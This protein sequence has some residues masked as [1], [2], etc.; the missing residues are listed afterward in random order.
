MCVTCACELAQAHKSVYILSSTQSFQLI[1]MWRHIRLNKKLLEKQTGMSLEH[2][3]QTCLVHKQTGTTHYAQ[4]ST[5]TD[6]PHQ[7]CSTNKEKT[8]KEDSRMASVSEQG[9][10]TLTDIIHEE[11]DYTSRFVRIISTLS[12][13]SINRITQQVMW[14]V[15]HG[16]H[17]IDISTPRLKTAV[18]R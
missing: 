4:Q 11:L 13:Q 15:L 16:C 6:P 10:T 12:P 18:V 7:S 3:G 9:E 5:L 1:Q 8:T 14:S 17:S 2:S